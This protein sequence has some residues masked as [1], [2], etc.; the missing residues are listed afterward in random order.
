MSEKQFPSK[1][2]K[3]LETYAQGYSET[4]DSASTDE[5]KKFILTSERNIYEIENEK[6]NNPKLVKMKE[7]L[8]SELAPFTEARGTE[9]AKIRY[10]L[11]TL[12]N[13]GIRI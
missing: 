4:V 11:W 13:R 1:F 10:C 5:I 12:E 2:K 9:M 6:E 7:D 8:K 3:K